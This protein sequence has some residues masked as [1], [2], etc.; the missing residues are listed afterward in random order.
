MLGTNVLQRGK[1]MILR[2]LED[3]ITGTEHTEPPI[4]LNQSKTRMEELLL[5]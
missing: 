4:L 1:T 2:L 3:L 5:R